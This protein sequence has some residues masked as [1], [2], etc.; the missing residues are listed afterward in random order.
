MEA[1]DVGAYLGRGG[2]A[3]V[4]RAI[5]R[6]SG[7]TVA[8]KVVDMAALEAAGVS[9]SRLDREVALHAPLRH[10]RVVECYGAFETS[11]PPGAAFAATTRRRRPLRCS[12]SS[13]AAAATCGPSSGAWAAWRSPP[14]RRSCA[15]SSRASRVPPRGVAH[16]DLKLSNVL[17]GEGGAKI[18]DFGV[19]CA[20][21]AGECRTLCGTPNYIAPE[22]VAARAADG[23]IAVADGFAT[24]ECAG[25]R[26]GAARLKVSGD[27]LRPARAVLRLRPPGATAR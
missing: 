20:T 17:L 15:R 19:A 3:T 12:C 6:S 18:C 10:A 8:L 25:P 4:F 13:T 11:S 24:L 7:R 26:G 22:V 9:A 23:R 2:F 21:G 14:P 27:G 5:E 1:Y 16:R